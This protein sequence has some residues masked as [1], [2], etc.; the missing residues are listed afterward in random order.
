LFQ[1]LTS[2]F[3]TARS[4]ADLYWHVNPNLEVPALDPA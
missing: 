1:L 4:S 2:K 3:F